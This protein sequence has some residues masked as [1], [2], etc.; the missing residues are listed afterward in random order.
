MGFGPSTS[1]S[2][3]LSALFSAFRALIWSSSYKHLMA[4]CFLSRFPGFESAGSV[5]QALD[6][7][8]SA[9]EGLRLKPT[10]FLSAF[11]CAESAN[12][13]QSSAGFT[14]YIPY[15]SLKWGTPTCFFLKWVVKFVPHECPHYPHNS[16][17]FLSSL[18][19]V[20]GSPKVYQKLF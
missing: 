12:F 7:Y 5:S 2:S 1:A 19:V 3:P 8:K 11:Y 16:N 14:G 17:T 9:A 6:S 10:A 4:S 18:A 13:S 20:F 15:K